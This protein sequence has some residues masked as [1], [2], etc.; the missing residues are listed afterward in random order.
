[1]FAV[2]LFKA[3]S[4]FERD[5]DGQR[6]GTCKRMME[7]HIAGIAC[8]VQPDGNLLLRPILS[9][10]EPLRGPNPAKGDDLYGFANAFSDRHELAPREWPGRSYGRDRSSKGIPLHL[11]FSICGCAM[12]NRAFP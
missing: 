10:E 5:A 6:V 12:G 9:K 8:S 1:M 2:F 4:F 11:H 7:G 3:F